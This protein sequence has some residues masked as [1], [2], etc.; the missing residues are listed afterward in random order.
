MTY[1]RKGERTYGPR[2]GAYRS[3]SAFPPTQ[4]EQENKLKSLTGGI[5]VPLSH[6]LNANAVKNER[7]ARL[8]KILTAPR[9]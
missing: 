3:C 6:T 1:K 7:L 9:G 4:I 2:S 5:K 8:N